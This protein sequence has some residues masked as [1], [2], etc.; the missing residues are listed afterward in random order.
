M[1][2]T[3]SKGTTAEILNLTLSSTDDIQI[4]F[5]NAVNAVIIKCRT[6]ADIQIRTS[7]SAP[8]YYTLPSGGTLTLDVS[9]KFQ[10]GVVKP[11]NLWLRSVSSTPVAE[12]MGLYGN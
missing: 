11:T 3:I 2:T 1:A 9:T 10:D 8:H 4:G 5:V 12:V 6:A 7:R